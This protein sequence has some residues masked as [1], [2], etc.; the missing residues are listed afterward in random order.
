MPKPLF[1]QPSAHLRVWASGLAAAFVEHLTSTTGTSLK[2][3]AVAR[4]GNAPRPSSATNT[5]SFFMIFP[6]VKD[7]GPYRLTELPR[8]KHCVLPP[9]P[10]QPL[11]FDHALLKAAT[12]QR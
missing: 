10:F 5:A 6:P 11:H 12:K 7:F 9:S 1:S 4:A 3:A 8:V 2:V